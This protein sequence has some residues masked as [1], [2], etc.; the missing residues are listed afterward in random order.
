MPH[1]SGCKGLTR[2]FFFCVSCI[3]E[4]AG[5]LLKVFKKSKTTSHVDKNA[6]LSSYFCFDSGP[7]E[8]KYLYLL[9]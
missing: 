4:N 6:N 3:V 8:K 9:F 1:Q 2:E 5:H 7:K